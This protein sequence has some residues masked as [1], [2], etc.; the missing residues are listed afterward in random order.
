MSKHPANE[1]EPIRASQTLQAQIA[2]LERL[3]KNPPRNSRLIEFG[4]ELAAYVLDTYNLHNRPMKP[5][6][7][8]QYAEAL[9][10]GTWGLTGDTIKFGADGLLKD[11]QNRLSAVIQSGVPMTS[12]VVFGID[13]ELFARMDIGKVRTGGDVFAIEGLPY[14]NVSAAAVRWLKILTSGKPGDRGARFS[15]EELLETY[16]HEVDPERLKHSIKMALEVRK[17]TGQPP[18]TLAA[19]HYLFHT[20]EPVKAD[21]FFTEWAT[22]RYSGAK[23]RSPVALMQARLTELANAGAGRVHENMRNL[24]IITAWRAYVTGDRR[25]GRAS[26]MFQPGEPVPEPIT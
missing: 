5:G 1:H 19:L 4:P 6:N 21:T 7:V 18:A 3:I 14:A 25:F 23:S 16:R 17:T 12:H 20:E 9:T 8:K 13:P 24:V 10:D 11:G 26:L 2:G 15:N 22:G